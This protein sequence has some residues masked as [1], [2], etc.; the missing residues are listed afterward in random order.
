MAKKNKDCPYNYCI[1][2][3]AEDIGDCDGEDEGHAMADYD[4]DC[5]GKKPKGCMCYNCCKKE[6]KDG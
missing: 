3:V 5:N 4:E 6:D 1:H 2:C